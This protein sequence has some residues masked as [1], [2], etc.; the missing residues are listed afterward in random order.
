MNML[1]EK[2][3]KQPL[4]ELRR[5]AFILALP[6]GLSIGESVY[7]FATP[8]SYLSAVS[9]TVFF[10]TMLIMWSVSMWCSLKWKN[11]P[12]WTF[13]AIILATL[14]M[15]SSFAHSLYI[16]SVASPE[17]CLAFNEYISDGIPGWDTVPFSETKMFDGKCYAF[18]TRQKKWI[19]VS[20]DASPQGE[21]SRKEKAESEMRVKE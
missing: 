1:F 18:E 8:W 3:E 4:K 16:A 12:A 6:F 11:F 20:Y 21:M 15:L 9:A 14:L 10:V 7:M 13:P 5:Y 2:Q 17:K 19:D